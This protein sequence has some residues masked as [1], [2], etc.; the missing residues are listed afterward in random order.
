VVH[1]V[2]AFAELNQGN[3]ENDALREQID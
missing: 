1:A 3:C 2:E